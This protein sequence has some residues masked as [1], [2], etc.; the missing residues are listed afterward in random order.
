MKKLVFFSMM[1][2][3]APLVAADYGCFDGYAGY[4]MMGGYSGLYGLFWVL[5]AALVFSLT[6]WLTY[7]MVIKGRT[8]NKAKG[9]NAK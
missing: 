2:L 6:F 1:L 4:G 5:I 8:D 3:A 7:K 9:K